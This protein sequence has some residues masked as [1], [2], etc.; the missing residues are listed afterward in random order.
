MVDGKTATELQA[1]AKEIWAEMCKDHGPMGLPWTKIP[2]KQRVEFCIKLE[3]KFP[4]LHLC[5]DHYKANTVATSD[6][7]HWYKSCYPETEAAAKTDTGKCQRS[8][9]PVR[10]QKRQHCGSSSQHT[11]KWQ[12]EEENTDMDV[13]GEEHKAA[14]EDDEEIEDNNDKIAKSDC[15]GE[16]KEE[17]NE[18]EGADISTVANSLGVSNMSTSTTSLVCDSGSS[19]VHVHTFASAQVT[20]NA[21]IQ[22]PSSFPTCK[23]TPT[24]SNDD[25]QRPASETVLSHQSNSKDSELMIVPPA[26]GTTND[27]ENAGLVPGTSNLVLDMKKDKNTMLITSANTAW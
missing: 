6:Y 18:D 20:T 16:N 19:M 4:V 5:A 1:K 3:S 26:S 21:L 27:K 17:N 22:I 9:K 11:R 25:V 15:D 24:F 2:A 13:D 8:A 23:A 14:E 10:G 7:S 12:H